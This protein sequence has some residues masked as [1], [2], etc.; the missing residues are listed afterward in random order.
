ML[1]SFT[2]N[3]QDD[4]DTPALCPLA[5]IVALAIT[6]HALEGID[7][8]EDLEKVRPSKGRAFAKLAVRQSMRD[9]PLFRLL[10]ARKKISPNLIWKY[11]GLRKALVG[12]GERAGYAEKFN[13]YNLRRGHG[14][15]LDSE[16][17]PSLEVTFA[18]R[19]FSA[20][21]IRFGRAASEADGSQQ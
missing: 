2:M 9:V 12:L 14:N 11:G 3:L 6:D 7:G 20:R 4:P 1:S 16:A 15:V 13:A 18:N 17:T 8:V 10:L 21:R 19:L 5:Q